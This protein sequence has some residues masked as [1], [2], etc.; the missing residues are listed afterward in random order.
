[1]KFNYSI[2]VVLMLIALNACNMENK[3]TTRE[4]AIQ[5]IQEPKTLAEVQEY[6]IGEWKSLSVE[7]RPTEDRTGSGVIQPTYLRRH[8]KY[9]SKDKFIGTITMY[10]DNYGEIPLLEF[11]FKGDLNWGDQH[12]IAEGAWSI[13]Y[14]LNE[15]FA[16]TPLNDQAAAM[17]N[18]ALPEGMSPFEANA[19]KD[20]LGKAFPMFHIAEDQV[21]SDY[22]LIYFKNG[23][24]FMGA[25]HVDG[26]PFDKV[27]N[28]PH[29]LQIPLERI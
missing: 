2:Q 16:V 19:K 8:F 22:D 13:D 6:A 7:L 29:Q 11:E 1:M 14:V 3:K 23:L 28:R 17:L 18:A 10:A 5:N 20:I 27:E 4:R 9:L 24:L 26:T 25:K 21:V 12:P 15:G